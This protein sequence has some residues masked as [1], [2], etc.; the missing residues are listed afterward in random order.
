MRPGS[1]LGMDVVVMVRYEESEEDR[2]Y[3]TVVEPFPDCSASE[4][5][6]QL[7]AC[8]GLAGKHK[9]TPG[10]VAGCVPL[11]HFSIIHPRD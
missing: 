1:A 2:V 6:H 3:G 7:G 11:A 9:H 4:W 10:Y 5:G 8:S